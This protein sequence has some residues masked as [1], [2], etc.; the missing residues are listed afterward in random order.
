FV[1][2]ARALTGHTLKSA[3]WR[4]LAWPLGTLTVAAGLGVFPA[5]ATLPAGAGGW[6]GIAA[7]GLSVHTAQVYHA[8]WVGLAMPLFLLAAGLP[9]AFLATGL[10]FMPIL[11]GLIDLPATFVA[12]GGM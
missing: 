4:A 6:V 8:P 5:P 2:G 12:V 3:M 7:R 1:W 10:R 11:R 9:L